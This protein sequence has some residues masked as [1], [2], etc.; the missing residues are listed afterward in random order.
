[1][2]RTLG[3][4]EAGVQ[5]SFT[6]TKVAV[7]AFLSHQTSLIRD[8]TKK[9]VTDMKVQPENCIHAFMTVKRRAGVAL[10]C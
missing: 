4:S 2:S 9:H 10:Q 3:D 5:Q 8:K 7:R 1:M 6:K